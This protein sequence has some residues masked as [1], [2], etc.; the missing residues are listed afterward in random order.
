[1]KQR[2]NCVYDGSGEV[3]LVVSGGKKGQPG[4]PVSVLVNRNNVRTTN[5]FMPCTLPSIGKG[6]VSK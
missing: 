3:S 2:V 1:M 4:T 5:Y 6:R